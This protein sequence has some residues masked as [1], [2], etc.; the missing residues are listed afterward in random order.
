MDQVYEARDG[1]W[2]PFERLIRVDQTDPEYQSHKLAPAFYAQAWLTVH[3]GMVGAQQGRGGKQEE[4]RGLRKAAR[5]LRK[6][7]RE[8]EK[9]TVAAAT[10]SCR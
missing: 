3:Q 8:N 6:K 7:M 2:I 1:D 4:S 9:E 5:R 10:S